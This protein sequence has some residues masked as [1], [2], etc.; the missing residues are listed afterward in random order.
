[1]KMEPMVGSDDYVDSPLV[2]LVSS[3]R[4]RGPEHEVR[5]SEFVE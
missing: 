1:M 5:G 4:V 3:E 2:R